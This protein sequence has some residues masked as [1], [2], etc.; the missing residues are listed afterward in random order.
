MNNRVFCANMGRIYMENVLP[1]GDFVNEA[2]RG[3]IV[4][5]PAKRNHFHT[6]QVGFSQDPQ[7]IIRR[8][9][10]AEVANALA[11]VAMIAASPRTH[12]YQNAISSEVEQLPA[13]GT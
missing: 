13:N 9:I 5:Q 12:I 3:N 2:W 8:R 4:E 11:C 6:D 10:N 1:Y 7:A